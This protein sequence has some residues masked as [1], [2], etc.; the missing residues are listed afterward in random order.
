MVFIAEFQHSAATLS[1][2]RGGILPLTVR[3]RCCPTS[4]GA[5]EH[6]CRR[7]ADNPASPSN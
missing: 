5:S 1:T 2:E 6:A 7:K 4:V 3:S